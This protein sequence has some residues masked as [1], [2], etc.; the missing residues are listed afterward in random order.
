M[1]SWEYDGE[2]R[3]KSYGDGSPN[4]ICVFKLDQEKIDELANDYHS[5]ETCVSPS[6]GGGGTIQNKRYKETVKSDGSSSRNED[7]FRCK[8]SRERKTRR[9]MPDGV[10]IIPGDAVRGASRS[11]ITIGVIS[12]RDLIP[13]TRW[14]RDTEVRAR[15]R[16]R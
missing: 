6:G 2:L 16:A 14:V 9:G 15:L 5:A 3:D 12:V 13:E 8:S 11:G 10:I 4:E 1:I 7:E